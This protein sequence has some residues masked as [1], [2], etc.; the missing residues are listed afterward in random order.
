MIGILALIFAGLAALLHVVIFLMESVLWT[1]PRVWKRFGVAD[2]GAADITR[3]M[4]YNQG[5]YNLFLAVGAGI[6]VVLWSVAGTGDVAGRTLLL[7]SLGSMVAAALVL[8]TSGAKYLR[9]AVIQGTLPAVGFVLT[10]L[11]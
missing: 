8:T 9:P 4:A 5:F 2:Q 10:L 1:R 7:F 3:P 11:A 6:G